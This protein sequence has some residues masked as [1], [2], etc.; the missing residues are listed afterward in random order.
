M[1]RTVCEVWSELFGTDVSPYADF[2][3]LGGDSL[4]ILDM[5]AA[6]RLRGLPVRSS[7]ALRHPT[8]ARLA[9]RLTLD[10][11]SPLADPAT[12][13]LPALAGDAAGR[14]AQLD[15]QPGPADAP[16]VVLTSLVPGR[17]PAP[18]FVAHSTD[19]LQ[20]EQLAVRAW[21]VDRPALS[22]LPPG[23]RAAATAGET[24]EATAGHY[25]AALRREQ[26]AGPY[27]L[28]GFGH[29]AVLAFELARQLRGAGQTVAWLAMV[30]PPAPAPAAAPGPLLRWRV[31]RLARRFGLTG[32]ED[33]AEILTRM[34]QAGWYDP[35][36]R[37]ADLPR[38]Q[39][40]W[41]DLARAVSGYRPAP[42]DGRVLLCQDV[43]TAGA[44][45]DHWR[46][47]V[48]DLELEVFDY[49]LDSPQPLLADARLAELMRKKLAP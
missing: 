11:D 29:A 24:I 10:D 19:H 28:L 36:V 17:A 44:T 41:A 8:P 9:E 23:L 30:R 18:L 45:E 33:A 3:D 31:T 15:A 34:R 25:L 16:A 38:L 40:A 12:P 48:T 14:P 20:A 27:H 22:M 47:A 37:P 1:E 43:S 4:T 5:V 21:L 6:A 2:F 46:P 42:Y 35:E 13:A 26:P 49:G 39:L 7:L 32:E